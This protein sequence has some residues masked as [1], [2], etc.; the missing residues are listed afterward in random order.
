MD[1]IKKIILEIIIFFYFPENYSRRVLKST[2]KKILG[3]V[4]RLT[5]IPKYRGLMPSRLQPLTSALTDS[6]QDLLG[7]P[8]PLG[9]GM[10]ILVIESVQEDARAT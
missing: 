8:C 9:P 5:S 2:N 1:K 3:L 7:L 10:A 4:G 6:L